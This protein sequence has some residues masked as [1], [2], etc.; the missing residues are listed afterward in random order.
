LPTA[1]APTV[2]PPESSATPRRPP[3]AS[4]R[5][6]AAAALSLLRAGVDLLER[7]CIGQLPELLDGDAPHAPRGCGAQAWSASEYLRTLDLLAAA[8]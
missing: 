4:S 6:A 5:P 3:A 7:D 8:V 2:Q 1:E